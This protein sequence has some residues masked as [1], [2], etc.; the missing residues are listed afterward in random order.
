VFD[1]SKP[2]TFVRL[3]DWVRLVR[4]GLLPERHFPIVLVGAKCDLARNVMADATRQFALRFNLNGY[5]ETSSKENINV[6]KPFAK[7]VQLFL[8]QTARNPL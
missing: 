5:I 3:Q 7:L 1:L 2:S 6:E 8:Y 4:T